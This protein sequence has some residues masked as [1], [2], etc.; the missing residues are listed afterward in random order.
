MKKM[1]DR[2]QNYIRCGDIQTAAVLS[3]IFGVRTV[4]QQHKQ[5]QEYHHNTQQHHHHNRRT[6]HV[7]SPQVRIFIPISF[8][9]GNLV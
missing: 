6:H 7:T 4:D 9:P 3:C 5:Q 1:H 2:L 8:A